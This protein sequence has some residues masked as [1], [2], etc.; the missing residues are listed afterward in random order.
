MEQQRVHVFT[1]SN[2][3]S[4]QQI[5]ADQLLAP[6][7]HPHAAGFAQHFIQ[8]PAPSTYQNIQSFN[9]VSAIP[10][11]LPYAPSHSRTNQL[12]RAAHNA[13]I[14]Q[15][16]PLSPND[17]Q[18]GSQARLQRDTSASRESQ[19]K[20]ANIAK[21]TQDP[22][23]LD[24][25]RKKLFA[26]DGMLTLTQHESANPSPLEDFELLIHGSLLRFETYFPYVDNVYSHRSTQKY[27]RNPFTAHY[28]D[29]R[30]KGR[31]P[32][33]KKTDDP[34][35]KKRKRVARERDQCDVKI[36]IVEFFPGVVV[37]SS[38]NMA[39]CTT[40]EDP[41]QSHGSERPPFATAPAIA[42]AVITTQAAQ[43]TQLA[44]EP[45]WAMPLISAGGASIPEASAAGQKIY[46][47]QRVN[48]GAAAGRA[49]ADIP[50][51]HRHTLEYSDSIKKSSIL[52][53]RVRDEKEK[54]KKQVSRIA[55]LASVQ[56]LA[57][58]LP[59]S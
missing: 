20:E 37:Q 18:I 25:W 51:A 42:A 43:S 1:Q 6:Q 50:P 33:T 58:A 41:Q 28:W 40:M 13:Q 39:M 2:P 9:G 48:G 38:H 45:G 34:N 32:G 56:V 30:L 17:V 15:P 36:K 59:T 16:F 55:S 12:L 57:K 31:P 8:T 3:T 7:L 47:I 54:R 27:K 35:K 19:P 10:V 14:Q 24:E 5:P 23:Q 26:A 29:C 11:P 21:T 46:T 52:R 49:D 44:N 4:F 53:E 22:P